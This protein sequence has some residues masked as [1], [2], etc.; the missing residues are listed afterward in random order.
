MHNKRDKCDYFLSLMRGTKTVQG[1]FFHSW[2]CDE[3]Q[4]AF[5]QQKSDTHKIYTHQERSLMGPWGSAPRGLNHTH[6]T[7]STESS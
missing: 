5:S 7:V 3:D 6:S 2:V 4:G 1:T